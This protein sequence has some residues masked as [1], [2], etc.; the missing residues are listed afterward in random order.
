MTSKIVERQLD[1]FRISR[2][3]R[4]PDLMLGGNPDDIGPMIP[5]EI[6]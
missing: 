3:M 1:Q 6:Y 5:E 4:E 2:Q